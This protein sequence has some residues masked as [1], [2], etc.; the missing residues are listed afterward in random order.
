MSE[1]QIEARQN[2][3]TQDRGALVE[4][5]ENVHRGKHEVRLRVRHDVG[6][7]SLVLHAI[8]DGCLCVFSNRLQLF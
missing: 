4:L 7:P 1:S 3:P 6:I 5:V 8:V 2:L